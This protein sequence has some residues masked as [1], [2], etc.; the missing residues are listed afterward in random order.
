ML[1]TNE[2]VNWL[3]WVAVILALSAALVTVVRHFWRISNGPS[4]GSGGKSG[5]GKSATS[6]QSQQSDLVQI[7]RRRTGS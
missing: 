1:A 5:C 4:C 3:D 7:R 6:P 2:L